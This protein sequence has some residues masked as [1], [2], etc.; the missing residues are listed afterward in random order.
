MLGAV[1]NG[2]CLP[3]FFQRSADF[4]T[5]F[6]SSEVRLDICC[7]NLCQYLAL[8]PRYSLKC[9]VEANFHYY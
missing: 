9:D 3:D 8:S 6:V 7:C 4:L 1:R 2:G 5:S